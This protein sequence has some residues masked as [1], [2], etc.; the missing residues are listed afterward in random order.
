MSSWAVST[1]RG[2]SG[3]WVSTMRCMWVQCS[4]LWVHC[5]YNAV[6][7][8][9][10]WYIVVQYSAL[11]VLC[12]ASAMWYS[13]VQFGALWVHCG[14]NAATMESRQIIISRHK[15]RHHHHHRHIKQQNVTGCI[16]Y[17]WALCAKHIIA[18]LNK[19]CNVYSN[20]TGMPVTHLISFIL[21]WTHIDPVMPF[22]K[23]LASAKLSRSLISWPS[24]CPQP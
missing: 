22:E 12:G 6:H 16:N 2:E 14:Y 20:F 7:S 15:N 1:L 10:I 23:W 21:T 3:C 4:A 5:G 8:G 9:N 19:S 18:S 11:W 24:M 17:D 13:V